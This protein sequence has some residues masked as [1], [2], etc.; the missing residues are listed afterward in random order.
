MTNLLF[1]NIGILELILI[2]FTA[3]SIVLV[4]PFSIFDIIKSKEMSNYRKLIWI[5]FILMAPLLGA[6]I[7]LLWGRKQKAL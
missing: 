6:I 3:I 4:I 7:Y 1:Y 2:A 5:L